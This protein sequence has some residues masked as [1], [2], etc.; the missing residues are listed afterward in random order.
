MNTNLSIPS[1]TTIVSG[2][3]QDDEVSDMDAQM[4]SLLP[5]DEIPT[6]GLDDAHSDSLIH[7]ARAHAE[8]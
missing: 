8:I 2:D 1:V 3:D 4:F 7:E 5:H 6:T